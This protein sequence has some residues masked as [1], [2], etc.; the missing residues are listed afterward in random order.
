MGPLKGQ[1]IIEI[2]GIGPGPFAAMLLA[3]MGANVIRVERPGGSM[4]TATH[5]TKLDFLNR[6]KRCISINLKNPDGVDTVLTML[7]QADRS[8]RQAEQDLA[9][10]HENLADLTVQNQG[11]VSA[12]RKLESDLAD[13]RGEAEEAKGEAAMADD[14]SSKVRSLPRVR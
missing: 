3:D 11:F 1:T 9:D 5:N 14:R 7:E 12:K 4:F 2:A 6:N 8:R 10:S 13:L